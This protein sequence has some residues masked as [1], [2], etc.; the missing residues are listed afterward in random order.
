MEYHF[1][2]TKGWMNDPNGLVLVGDTYHI[3]YQYNPDDIVWGPMHWG[4]ATSSDLITWKHE[5]IAIFP[6]EDEYIFS[7]SCIL[8]EE[9]LSGLGSGRPVL[10][11]FYTGH[12]PSTGIQKQCIAFSTDFINFTRYSKNP[13]IDSDKKD[14]RDPKVFKNT[15]RGGYSMVIAAGDH[16][17]FF[18]SNN[19]LDWEK[20]GDTYLPE[21]DATGI[22]ECPDCFLLDGK[23]VLTLSYIYTDGRADNRPIEYF[24]GDFNGDKFFPYSRTR[25]LDYGPDN[26]AAV[27]FNGTETPIMLGWAKNWEYVNRTPASEYRGMLTIPRKLAIQDGHIVQTPVGVSGDKIIVDVGDT[28]SIGNGSLTISVNTDCLIVARRMSSVT[29]Y[30]TFVVPRWVFG[31]CRLEVVQDENYYEIFVDYGMETISI[32]LFD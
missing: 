21:H 17:E 15:I 18:H 16:L 25:K 26:Y 9:D 22:C 5:K 20:T 8:D 2:P 24:V 12:N 10:I 19:L 7:G 30:N 6:T 1:T 14:F 27:T 4:H 32:E 11:A 3:F 31:S 13:V 29:E 23:W 28:I